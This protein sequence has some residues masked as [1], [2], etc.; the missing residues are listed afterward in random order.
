MQILPLAK[1]D[2][3]ILDKEL[4]DT[5]A[6]ILDHHSPICVL[7]NWS[8]GGQSVKRLDTQIL[9]VLAVY[10]TLTDIQ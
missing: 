6:S 9:Q 5:N 1:E 3:G 8:G 7:S 2:E 4:K 10:L